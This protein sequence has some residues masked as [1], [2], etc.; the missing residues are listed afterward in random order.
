LHV[1]G[2]QFVATHRPEPLHVCMPEQLPQSIARP[3]PSPT[4]PQYFPVGS[5]HARGVQFEVTQ[6]PPSHIWPVGQAPQ[7][8]VAKQPL[9]M[10]PQ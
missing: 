1:I 8:M 4:L 6:M 5:M 9:P 10:T 3:Q 2:T 7:S